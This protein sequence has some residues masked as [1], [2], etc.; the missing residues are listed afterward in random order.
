MEMND[1]RGRRNFITD[2]KNMCYKIYC[3]EQKST[4]EVAVEVTIEQE[5]RSSLSRQRLFNHQELKP[6]PASSISSS[7][8]DQSKE[9]TTIEGPKSA[10]KKLLR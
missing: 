8:S 10:Y 3:C 2:L 6:E 1:N 7:D 5:I 4:V 9:S